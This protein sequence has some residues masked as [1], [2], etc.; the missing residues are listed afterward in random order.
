MLAQSIIQ[1]VPNHPG[2]QSDGGHKPRG[3]QIPLN[4]FG[5]SNVLS[6]SSPNTVSAGNGTGPKLLRD[7][8]PILMLFCATLFLVQA[9]ALSVQRKLLMS[10]LHNVLGTSL[11]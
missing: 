2:F 7:I 5:V 11:F 3:S 4:L 8:D 10:C 6:G 1:S 9:P